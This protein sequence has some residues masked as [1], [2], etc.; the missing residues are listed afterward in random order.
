MSTAC[1]INSEP[2]STILTSPFCCFK[3]QIAGAVRINFLIELIRTHNLVGNT[4]TRDT[5]KVYWSIGLIINNSIILVYITALVS[6]KENYYKY[7][8]NFPGH[9]SSAANRNLA[10]TISIAAES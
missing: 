7:K 9:F 6:A 10:T 4:W 1:L 2:G 3:Q 8:Q 5:G